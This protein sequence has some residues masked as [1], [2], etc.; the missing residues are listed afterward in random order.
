VCVVITADVVVV[1]ATAAAERKI[2]LKK[3]PLTVKL[4]VLP[5]YGGKIN[6]LTYML[7]DRRQ[8]KLILN[9]PILLFSVLFGEE[10]KK[11]I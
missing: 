5:T 3:I 11:G 9:E 8:E 1:V 2:K 10:K 7:A 4:Y 6:G